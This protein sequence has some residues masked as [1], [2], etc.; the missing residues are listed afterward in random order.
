[1]IE[2]KIGQ[3]LVAQQNYEVNGFSDEEPIKV[4]A[5][6]KAVVNA[7]GYIEHTTGSARGKIQMLNEANFKI[8]G[9]D[10]Q[11]IAKMILDRL[12]Y[13]CEFGTVMEDYDLEEKYVLEQIECELD[14]VLV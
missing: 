13:S 6:S 8:R 1:M 7:N 2:V 3:E 12:K 11:N 5:G 10:I 14:R 4:K 9:S